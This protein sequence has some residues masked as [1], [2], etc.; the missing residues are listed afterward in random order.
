MLHKKKLDKITNFSRD[1]E[2]AL[3][4]EQMDINDKLESVIDS[5]RNIPKVDIP[6]G[7]EIDLSE[8]N[9]LLKTLIEEQQKPCEISIE[10]N[11]I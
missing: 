1:K 6:E 7:K 5:I 3:F 9:N 10:L 8:V 11:L 4:Q 2:F